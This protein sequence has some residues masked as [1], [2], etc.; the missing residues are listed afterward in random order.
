MNARKSGTTALVLLG[1]LAPGASV[2]A[3][4]LSPWPY[5]ESCSTS[6]FPSYCF[7]IDQTANNTYSHGVKASA[8]SGIGVVGASTSGFGVVGQ[9]ASSSTDPD[10]AAGVYGSVLNGGTA[11]GV[12]GR[13]SGTGMFGRSDGSGTGVSG[14]AAGTGI[15]MIGQ[16]TSNIGVYGVSDSVVF[17]PPAER[18]GVLGTST[19]GVG[20]EGTSSSSQGVSG[21]SSCSTGGT[22]IGVY[23]TSSGGNGVWGNTSST[24]NAAVVGIAPSGG[25]AFYGTGNLYITG[26]TAWKAGGGSWA[27]TSDRR[28]KKD[29]KDFNQGLVEL[30][31]VQ[32]VRFHYNGLGGT[33]DDGKEFVGVIAQDLEKILPSMVASRMGKLHPTDTEDTAI[34]HVDPSE[35]TYLLINAVKEQQK[36]IERQEA[37]IEAL[38]EGRPPRLSSRTSIGGLE[39]SLAL[40]L[41]PVGVVVAIKRRRK[42]E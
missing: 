2:L 10:A 36:V 39:A 30:L 35:F 24:T 11:T 3:Q 5:S 17:L 29:V 19:S 21:S 12:Y 42:A 15:G 33:P 26:S 4:N 13:S 23:G 9:T 28:V 37:R 22:C 18:I 25:Y 20:V 1:V 27:P 6:G 14:Y 34:K 7:E 32:P 8:T 31:K 16:G 41:L 40:G 38:E